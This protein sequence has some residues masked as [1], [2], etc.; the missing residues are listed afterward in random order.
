MREHRDKGDPSYYAVIFTSKRTQG[1]KGYA[2][3]AQ[4]IEELARE[5]PGFLG[6]E[7]TQNQQLG[8]TISYWSSLEAIKAWREHPAHKVAQKRGKNEWYKYYAVRICKV[9]SERFFEAN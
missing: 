3:M 5:Q 7:S 1:D 2:A 4:H 9:E 6:I 8:I